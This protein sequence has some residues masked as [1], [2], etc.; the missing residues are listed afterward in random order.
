[1]ENS[2]GWSSWFSPSPL[3][4]FHET[5]GSTQLLRNVLGLTQEN[6]LCLLILQ[7]DSR[8]F[9]DLGMPLSSLRVPL[10]SNSAVPIKQRVCNQPSLCRYPSNP[11]VSIMEFNLKP[12][13]SIKPV[14]FP[15][16]PRSSCRFK[17]QAH[18]TGFISVVTKGS[19]SDPPIFYFTAQNTKRSIA[20][21]NTRKIKA[22]HLCVKNFQCTCNE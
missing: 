10:H 1:M 19:Y 6:I 2:A 5:C 12:K 16:V 14:G 22:K 20:L 8:Y 15:S 17:K 3:F 21:C 18:R 11:G 4:L 13:V 9:L 7:Y